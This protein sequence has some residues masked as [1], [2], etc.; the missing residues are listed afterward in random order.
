MPIAIHSKSCYL[1]CAVLREGL[2]N[3]PGVLCVPQ[4]DLIAFS[5]VAVGIAKISQLMVEKN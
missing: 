2:A 5:L 3:S 1:A 4:N